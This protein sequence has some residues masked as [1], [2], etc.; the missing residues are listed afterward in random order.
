[1][2]GS[3]T[4]STTSLDAASIGIAGTVA[5][6]TQLSLTADTIDETGTIITSLLTGSTTG[7]A[8]LIG[9]NQIAALGDFSAA[10]FTLNDTPDLAVTGTV[11]GGASVTITDAGALTVPGSITG[12]ATSLTG[13]S[14]GIGGTVSAPTQLALTATAGAID[15][16]GTIA[17]ALLTGSATGSAALIGL[18]Q[19]AAL[20]DFSAANFALNDTP[21]LAVTGTVDGGA[22]VTITDAGTLSVPG[23]IT[24]STTSLTGAAL[25]LGGAVTASTQLTLTATAGAIDEAGTIVT[26][27]LTG[28]ATGSASLVGAN[29]IAALG[30]FAAAG[31]T[32]N[33]TPNLAVTGTVDGGATVTIADTGALTV[34]GSITGSTTSLTGASIGIGGTVTAPTQL[35]LAATAGAIDETGTII[36]SLLTGSA[37]GSASL[38]GSNQ[39][40]ALGDFS[41]ANFALNDIPDLAVTGTVDGGATVAITDAG[42][43]SVAGSITGSTTSLTGAALSLGGTV[44]A[45][46]Q[47]TLTA[48]AGAI[49]E[50]GTIITALL[51]GS[52]TGSAS[53]IGSNQIAALGDFTAAGFILD[54][55][56]NLAVTGTIDGG[57]SVAITDTGA[58]TVPGSITGSTTSL[59]ATSIGI[60][61]TVAAATELTLTAGTIDETGTIITSLLTGST[62]GSAALIGSNQIAA[63]G[64]FSAAGFT[65]NDTPDLAVTGTVDGG[66]SVTITDAG[67]LTVPGSITGSTTSLTGASIGIGGTVTAP[68]QLTLTATAGAIDETGTIVTALLTGSATGSAAL[69]GLNQVAA[70]GDFSAAGFTL[71]DTPD[72]AVTGTVDGGA[73]VTITDA[74]ALTVPGS[75]AGTTTSLTGASISIGGTVTAP[76]QLTLTATAGAINETG[77]IATA[78]LTGSA[79]GSASLA[80]SNKI[81]ALGDFSAANFALNDIPDL[82]VTGTVDGGATV[83]ITDAGT[84]SVAGSITGST[85]SL[86]GAALSL[87]GTVTAPTQLTLT[88][89]AARSTRV[90]RS[91]R[92][93]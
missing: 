89:T 6:A 12:S 23:S 39:V 40:A 22:N 5:A 26:A 56:P 93:C 3:I 77:R 7:S 51:T 14:I 75:I 11:D 91:S 10:G 84:L 58:L 54:D 19:V 48:T 17:T 79:T 4:G 68:T 92:R 72:L 27:L 21:D 1:M 73:S 25:S 78:L 85:T 46:T 60:A 18:N 31:F 64:D 42:T 37:T 30:D 55:T 87:G 36:T 16:A 47:L 76:T 57:T 65:L 81:A 52:A 34:P 66:A 53:L 29:Q 69:I 44:T 59:D 24:G 45:P 13:A 15:E 82:A 71:N 50:S 83:T 86:T 28:S 80:G 2:P 67:A 70:L 8:S 35:T 90:E 33:D 63:L 43:L 61:G 32:L 88:A 38:I 74:G 41:A 62:T 20:G 9:A 49:D